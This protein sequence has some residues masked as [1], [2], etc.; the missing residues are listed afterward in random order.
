MASLRNRLENARGLAAIIARLAGGYL[1]FVNWS[2]RWE[3]EG[4][5]ALR[6]DLADGPVLLVMWHGRSL[7]GP[8]HWPVRDGQLTSLF[9]SSAIGRVSGAMQ[10]QF[11]LMPMEM[12]DGASNVANSRAILK[13]VREGVSIGMTGDGPLGPA[14][15]VQDAPLD[16]ARAMQRP[17]WGYAFETSR[18]RHLKTWDDMWVPYPFGHGRVVFKRWD[19]EVP[20]KVEEEAL[21]VLR[22]GMAQQ[23]DGLVTNPNAN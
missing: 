18:G 20:R 8:V 16:W 10:R 7:M 3:V 21:E 11:G 17:V 23:L 4:L 6:A 9:A 12:R 14:L 19:V 15:V 2:V 22:A 13:R 5:D 1:R